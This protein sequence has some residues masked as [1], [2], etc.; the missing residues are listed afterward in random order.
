MG[1]RPWVASVAE[2]WTGG[3]AL[4]V[5]NG[6][7]TYGIIDDGGTLKIASVQWTGLKPRTDDYASGS[8]RLR[9]NTDTPVQYRSITQP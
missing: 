6:T 1:E 2:K 7:G 9:T 3:D 4:W 8:Q 5:Y